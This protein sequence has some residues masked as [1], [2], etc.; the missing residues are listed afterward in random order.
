VSEVDIDARPRSRARRIGPVGTGGRTLVGLA[1]LGLAFAARPAGVIGGLQLHEIILGLVV[2]PSVT[3]ATGLLGRRYLSVPIRYVGPMA[4]MA[5]CALI[6]A[7]FLVPYTSG[8]AALFYG[9]SLLLA[10]VRGQPDCEA[11]ILSNWILRRDDQ[12][13][14]PT[15]TPL[16]ALETRLGHR[17]GA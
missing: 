16:D 8:A 2:F 17:S 10:A 7:L 13:G 12:I 5:N 3:V 15:F 14:C 6:V 4:I 1:L 11:T 9:L